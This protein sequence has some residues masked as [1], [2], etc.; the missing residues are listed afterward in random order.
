MNLNEHNQA[1]LTLAACFLL[2]ACF[3]LQCIFSMRVKSPTVDEFV[4]LPVG[5]S[6]LVDGDFLTD[7]INP[8]FM[9][10]WAALPLLVNPPRW[11]TPVDEMRQRFWLGAYRFMRE[12]RERYHSMFLSGRCMVLI[13]GLVLGWYVFYWT[14][15]LYGSKCALGALFIYTL[16]PNLLAH[17][18]LIT[19]DFGGACFIFLT[20]FHFWRWRRT[21]NMKHLCAGALFFGLALLSKLT[22]IFLTPI[23]VLLFVLD[24]R[25]ELKSYQRKDVRRLCG[26]IGVFAAVSLAVVHAGY[27]FQGILPLLGDLPFQSSLLE[28]VKRALPGFMPV[29]LPEGFILGIDH[30]LRH[31]AD[32]PTGS[33]FLLGELSSLGWWYYFI[34]AFLVKVP[35]TIQAF[36]IA[37]LILKLK[38]RGK[39]PIC[40]ELF[41][42]L[43]AAS[44]FVLISAFTS[45]NIGFRHILM[46]LPMVIVLG[47]RV[48]RFLFSE[49]KLGAACV[50]TGCLW[51]L[52]TTIRIFPNHLT[53]FNELAGGP[54]GGQRILSD[55]NLDW[56]QDLMQLK[57]YLDRRENPGIKLGYFGRTD[58]RV[59]GIEFER[60]TDKAQ[61]GLIVLS[62]TFFQG[63]PYLYPVPDESKAYEFAPADHFAWLRK[64]EPV[65][66]VGH[67]L[68]VFEIKENKEIK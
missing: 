24:A 14:K 55:S 37:A 36:G 57:N 46:I 6:L 25:N 34:V 35:V 1:R 22:G 2:L 4:H 29:P 23:L 7:P 39:Q 52:I 30:A 27:G 44:F 28:G 50:A 66:K 59:Y 42:A 40:D 8:P 3:A 12:N 5:Y 65:E 58:P 19:A 13:L 21:D 64:H 38:E 31:D 67:T 20:L 32:L 54:E 51:L 60:L 26:R 18:R 45:L 33:F 15:C 61:T 63:R 47:A 17:T 62:M 49:E 9:R 43:P 53:Y 41:L 48:F 56:G 10:M 11:S 16:S 68:L